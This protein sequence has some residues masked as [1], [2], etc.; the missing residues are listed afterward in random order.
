MTDLKILIAGFGGQGIQFAGKLLAY[1]G[2]YTGKEVSVIPS[3]GPEMR[4]G[5][6]NCSVN[7]SDAPIAS[8]LVVNPEELIAMN[9]PS[10]D[11]FEAACESGAK[12]FVDSTLISRKGVRDDVE[13]FYVPATGIAGENGFANLA[14]VVLCGKFLK[15]TGL[16][17]LE[18]AAPIIKKL[19]PAKKPELYELNMKALEIGYGL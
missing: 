15:E 19:V 11:K 16:C 8:P 12:I 6:S 9:L 1:I 2:M 4:G 7:V 3:Y 17:D 18:T 14:N 10:F 13:Y 5:T